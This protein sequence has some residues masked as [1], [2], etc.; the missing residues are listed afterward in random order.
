MLALLDVQREE[1]PK[2]ISRQGQ[3]NG[4]KLVH[5]KVPL[6]ALLSPQ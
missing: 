1:M 4:F 2:F 6:E 5:F 3:A